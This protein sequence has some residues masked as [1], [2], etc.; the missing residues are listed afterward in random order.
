[1]QLASQQDIWRQ[2][3]VLTDGQLTNSVDDQLVLRLRLQRL[4]FASSDTLLQISHL[5]T[6]ACA[7]SGELIMEDACD[8]DSTNVFCYVQGTRC[9]RPTAQ[10]TCLR[11]H[12]CLHDSLS[13]L[14]MTSANPAGPSPSRLRNWLRG[15]LSATG[16]CF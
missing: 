5:R 10:G 8:T 6:F 14:N 2:G 7:T 1:M 3:P 16:Y 4:G 9:P 11:A 13:A 12:S 15:W